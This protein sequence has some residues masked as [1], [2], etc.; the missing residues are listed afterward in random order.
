MA[1]SVIRYNKGFSLLE[2]MIA[3][4]LL[5]MMT[6]WALQGLVSINKTVSNNKIRQ[7]AIKLGQ[8]L[9][10]DARVEPYTTLSAISP[11][12]PA[13][14]NRQIASYDIAF[15]ITPAVAIILAGVSKSVTYTIT[16]TTEGDLHTY[17]AQTMVSNHR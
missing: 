8:E 14:I 12:I 16:W 1:Q 2:A 3:I 11:L 9:L 7:E 17:V 13:T 15:T 10:V 4:L 5:A 6:M